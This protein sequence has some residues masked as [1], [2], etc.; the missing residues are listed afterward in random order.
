MPLL[1][2]ARLSLTE[3]EN[4]ETPAV[5]TYAPGNFFGNSGDVNLSVQFTGTNAI[6]WVTTPA[7]TPAAFA[8]GTSTLGSGNLKIALM[9]IGT[10]TAGTPGTQ[11]NVVTVNLGGHVLTGNLTI[12]TGN[13]D[14]TISVYNGTVN[15]NVSITSNNG[16]DD[17]QIDDPLASGGTTI[18]K[19]LTINEG[20]GND[21]VFFAGPLLTVAGNTVINMGSG[22]NSYN[23]M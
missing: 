6:A 17:V 19:S 16:A 9:G 7:T 3:L 22:N 20:G 10:N 2:N 18:G 5:M 1:R 12:I 23:L 11:G 21:S 8:T 15:G 4:R 13:G 14:D